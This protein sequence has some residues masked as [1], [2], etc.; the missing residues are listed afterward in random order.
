MNEILEKEKKFREKTMEDLMKKSKSGPRLW[1][2][3]NNQKI[4]TIM[5]KELRRNLVEKMYG[6]IEDKD[7]VWDIIYD[8]AKSITSGHN[9]P[10]GVFDGFFEMFEYAVAVEQLGLHNVR[11]TDEEYGDYIHK[12][13]NDF[14][15]NME[16]I[17]ECISKAVNEFIKLRLKKTGADEMID[18]VLDMCRKERL[19]EELDMCRENMKKNIKID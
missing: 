4:I 18:D 8:Y 3:Y 11:I 16:Y 10:E 9:M 2:I 1:E 7:A 14:D 5:K 13:S 17:D 15:I 6:R 12:I 19:D